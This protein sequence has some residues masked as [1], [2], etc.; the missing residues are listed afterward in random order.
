MYYK[1][2]EDIYNIMSTTITEVDKSE[3]SLVY[4]TQ[5]PCAMELSN[6]YLNMDEALK[7]VFATTAY[8]NGYSYYLELIANEQGI[9]RKQATYAVIKCKFEGKKNTTFKQGIIVRTQD[10]RLYSTIEDFTTGEDGIG[11]ANVCADESGSKYNVK[12]GEICKFSINYS[13]LQSVINEEEYNDAYDEESDESLYNRYIEKIRRPITSGNIYHYE[14]WCKEV[15]GV[16]DVKVIPLWDKDN[17]MNGRGSVKCVI[18]NSNNRKA[19][20]ELIQKVKDYIDPVDAHGEGQ[21]PIG[22]TLTV[23][24]VEEIPINIVAK[25]ELVENASIETVKENYIKSI[26]NYFSN[27]S[28]KKRKVSVAKLQGLLISLSDVNDV[29]YDDFKVNN[30]Y[31][32]IRLND[33]QVAVLGEVTLEVM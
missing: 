4:N 27:E 28:Y 7:K 17:G 8:V 20:P 19:S 31:E 23:T 22:A 2:A 26:E 11:Y 32:T 30:G 18:T 3:N 15:I 14:K 9:N 24:T 12:V 33:E 10:N 13:N 25:V 29:D 5:F 6:A 16:G 21:A 1:S